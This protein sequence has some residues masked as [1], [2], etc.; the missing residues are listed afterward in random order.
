MHIYRNHK[1]PTISS[2][3]EGS[4]HK[5]FSSHTSILDPSISTAL[6]TLMAELNEPEPESTQHSSSRSFLGISYVSYSNG[7]THCKAP[8][9]MMEVKPFELLVWLPI[10][11]YLEGITRPFTD[12]ITQNKDEVILNSNHVHVYI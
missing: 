10:V 4:C 2:S 6:S 8:K 11:R 1:A 12:L 7:F 5:L 3:Q 9:L